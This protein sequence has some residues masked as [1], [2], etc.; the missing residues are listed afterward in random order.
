MSMEMVIL[1]D[2]EVGS[3]AEWQAA[4]NA[5][6]YPLQLDPEM[7]FECLSGFLPSHLRGQLTGFECYHEQ[8]DQCMRDNSDIDFGH[9]WKFALSFVWLGSRWNEL[10]A[11]WMAGTA[12]AQATAGIIFDGEE[13]KLFTAAEARKMV[14]DLENPSPAAVAAME[15]IRRRLGHDS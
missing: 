8:A 13:G 3:I 2:R 9:D 12:Y 6:G 4:I 5:E 14:H 7:Q 1:S 11:A 15:E 10:I